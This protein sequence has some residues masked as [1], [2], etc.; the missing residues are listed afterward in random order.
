MTRVRARKRALSP[1]EAQLR[2][3]IQQLEQQNGLL[4]HLVGCTIEAFEYFD[5]DDGHAELIRAGIVAT[6]KEIVPE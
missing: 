6:Y 5:S 3:R 1:A 2:T 4:C